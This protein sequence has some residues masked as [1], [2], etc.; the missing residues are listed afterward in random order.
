MH[1]NCFHKLL[2]QH[3]LTKQLIAVHTLTIVSEERDSCTFQSVLQ[4][5]YV[6]QPMHHRMRVRQVNKKPGKY[7]ERTDEKR[8]EDG[9]ILCVENVKQSKAMVK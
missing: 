4:K 2:G 9:T 6:K 7:Q 8:S 5:G 1:V 3:E